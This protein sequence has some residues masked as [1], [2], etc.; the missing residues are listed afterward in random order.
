MKCQKSKNWRMTC[1]NFTWFYFVWID[2]NYEM[3]DI[4]SIIWKRDEILRMMM[5]NLMINLFLCH[6]IWNWFLGFIL[7]IES[8]FVQII[9][10]YKKLLLIFMDF[11]ETITI[12][13][14]V[15]M[16]F[17]HKIAQFKIQNIL[18]TNKHKDE[19]QIHRRLLRNS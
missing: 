9:W 4:F 1:P 6:L 3:Y 18:F 5:V 15:R 10:F 19:V 14:F 7:D 11:N 16:S 8:V 13:Y 2:W 17:L 12:I